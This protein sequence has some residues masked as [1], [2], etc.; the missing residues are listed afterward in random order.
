MKKNDKIEALI[1]QYSELINNLKEQGAYLNTI[2]PEHLLN[3]QDLLAYF[4][5]N[6]MEF[7]HPY[8]TRLNESFFRYI[9]ADSWS[10]LVYQ[11]LK[12]F[13]LNRVVYQKF[14]T[15]S[16]IPENLIK[17]PEGYQENSTVYSSSEVI[18]LRWIEVSHVIIKNQVLR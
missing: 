5:L 8:S 13:Y 15:L 10:T 7:A 11:I 2:R 4:K 17:L 12:I 18:L 3:Y 14:K 9:S 6:P 16:T 1:K